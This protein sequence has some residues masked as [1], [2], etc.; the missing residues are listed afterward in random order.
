M[1][2]TRF[3]MDVPAI[4]TAKKNTEINLKLQNYYYQL[5]KNTSSNALLNL[6]ERVGKCNQVWVYDLFR[7]MKIKDLIGTWLCYN[8][9]C[10]NCGKLRDRK[11]VV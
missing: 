9:F 8:K 7:K 1:D 11:S 5:G 3:A 6:S 2:I 10:A 4:I